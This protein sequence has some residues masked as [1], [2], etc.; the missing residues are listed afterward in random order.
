[1][2]AAV[3]PELRRP[4]AEGPARRAGDAADAAVGPTVAPQGAARATRL[5]T[6]AAAAAKAASN[7]NCGIAR[8]PAM[9]T[10]S[11]PPRRPRPRLPRGVEPRRQTYVTWITGG[12]TN[13]C[14]RTAVPRR[15]NSCGPGWRMPHHS[16]ESATGSGAAEPEGG[17][18]A[19][20]LNLQLIELPNVQN[21]IPGMHPMKLLRQLKGS[22]PAAAYK[23]LRHLKSLYHR[24][25][26]R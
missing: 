23:R 21:L 10:D 9:W 18:A 15:Q 25:D 19:K 13:C 2:V 22:A 26:K 24:R 4:D 20:T 11:S 16:G 7:C 14:G 3:P 12:T 5:P 6:V 1:M 17:E 8:I